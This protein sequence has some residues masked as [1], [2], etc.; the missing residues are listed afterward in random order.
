MTILT[1]EIFEQ[2][3][4]KNGGFSKEQ[5]SL[6]NVP[7]PLVRGWQRRII[8]MEFTDYSIKRFIE[9]KDSHIDKHNNN[10]PFPTTLDDINKKLDKILEILSR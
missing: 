9:L 10:M 1:N 4:S 6:F 5:L 2:G 7:Y 8:G 3:R